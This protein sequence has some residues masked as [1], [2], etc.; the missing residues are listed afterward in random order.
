M[1]VSELAAFLLFPAMGYAMVG[2][3]GV[4]GGIFIYLCVALRP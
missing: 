3:W 4:A 1:K 2:V